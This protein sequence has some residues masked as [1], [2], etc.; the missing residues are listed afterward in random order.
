[1]KSFYHEMTLIRFFFPFEIH[2]KVE[3]V[4]YSFACHMAQAIV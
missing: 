2:S 3:I 4:C 1:M